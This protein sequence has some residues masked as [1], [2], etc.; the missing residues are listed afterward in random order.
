MWIPGHGKEGK[1]HTTSPTHS[2]TY[3]QLTSNWEESWSHAR[4]WEPKWSFRRCSGHSTVATCQGSLSN[5]LSLSCSPFSQQNPSSL[6]MSH[7]TPSDAFPCSNNL[8][9]ASEVPFHQKIAPHWWLRAAQVGTIAKVG[10]R[11]WHPFF[12]DPGAVLWHVT[13]IS[14]SG[15][16]LIVF[17]V[18]QE[19]CEGT[20]ANGNYVGPRRH[21]REMHLSSGFCRN[22]LFWSPLSCFLDL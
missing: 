22:F 18:H 17:S 11:L 5:S 14:L 8:Y 13:P 12:A 3:L 16:R 6:P 15:F 2:Q 19:T 10:L 1:L 4:S 20:D 9:V 7:R 21:I